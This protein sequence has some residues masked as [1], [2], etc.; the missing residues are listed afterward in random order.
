MPR[1]QQDENF[2]YVQC[3]PF[4]KGIFGKKKKVQFSIYDEE[5]PEEGAGET[6]FADPQSKKE[7][8]KVWRDL[9]FCFVFLCTL[10]ER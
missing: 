6:G 8:G 9:I 2:P 3:F 4:W 1:N 7:N 10:S 5:R